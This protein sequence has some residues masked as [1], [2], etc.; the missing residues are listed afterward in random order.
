[1]QRGEALV[2]GLADI[3]AAVNQLADGGVLAIEAGQ[4]E[5]R[6]AEG[7]GVVRLSVGKKDKIN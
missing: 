5:R 3:G 1:M 4:V 2:V 6:V 7:V